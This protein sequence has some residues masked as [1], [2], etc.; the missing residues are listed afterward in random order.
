MTSH[1][2]KGGGHATNP[3]YSSTPG[4]HI[5]LANFKDVVYNAAS[6]TAVIGAGLT[7]DEVY[8]A[9]EPHGVSVV[10]GRVTGVGV[11]GFTLGGGTKFFDLKW[12]SSLTVDV[13]FRVLVADEPA[14]TDG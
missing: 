6:Q 13:S 7:W 1:Q 9:L 2:V 10:G 11:A 8:E 14:G 4:V 5:S 12:S 3:G